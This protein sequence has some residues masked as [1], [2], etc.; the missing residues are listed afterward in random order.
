MAMAIAAE[1]S[2]FSWW[3]VLS[4]IACNGCDP[5]KPPSGGLYDL[6]SVA[7]TSPD[8]PWIRWGIAAVIFAGI[9]ALVLRRRERY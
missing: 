2:W 7:G 6:Y 1:I 4:S 5:D 8:N 9:V 3:P